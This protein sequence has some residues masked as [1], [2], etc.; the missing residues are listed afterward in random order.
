MTGLSFADPE[1]Y[2]LSASGSH[3]FTPSGGTPHLVVESSE[4]TSTAYFPASAAIDHSADTAWETN[5]VAGT[6]TSL[7]LRNSDSSA[8]TLASYT[9]VARN[10]WQGRAPGEFTLYGSNDNATWTSVDSQT[11]LTDYTLWMSPGNVKN[12]VL[13]TPATFV[14]WK[15]VVTA[16]A[17]DSILNLG[18]IYFN[19]TENPTPVV[20]KYYVRLTD[21]PHGR[22]TDVSF[23]GPMLV[24]NWEYQWMVLAPEYDESQGERTGGQYWNPYAGT[25]ANSSE[26]YG[27]GRDMI[28]VVSLSSL[29]AFSMTWTSRMAVTEQPRMWYDRTVLDPDGGTISFDGTDEVSTGG[30]YRFYSLTPTTSD[31]LTISTNEPNAYYEIYSE[32]GV[33]TYDDYIED[34]WNDAT[35]VPEAGDGTLQISPVPGQEYVIVVYPEQQP[36]PE[37]TWVLTWAQESFVAPY[38]VS[39]DMLVNALNLGKATPGLT[40]AYDNTGATTDVEVPWAKRSIWYRFHVDEPSFVKIAATPSSSDPGKDPDLFLF[41]SDGVTTGTYFDGGSSTIYTYNP[42]PAG[43]EVYLMIAFGTATPTAD[44]EQAGSM[45]FDVKPAPPHT[46][47]V[48][49]LPPG[50]DTPGGGQNYH[51]GPVFPGSSVGSFGVMQIVAPRDGGL[52]VIVEGGNEGGTTYKPSVELYLPYGYQTYVGGSALWR[53]DPYILNTD[54]YDPPGYPIS[55]RT[56]PWRPVGTTTT[57]PVTVRVKAG[58]ILK[59][60]V[61]V[62]TSGA[63]VRWGMATKDTPSPWFSARYGDI[64]TKD[65]TVVPSGMSPEDAAVVQEKVAAWPEVF[66]GPIY[67]GHEIPGDTRA[68]VTNYNTDFVGNNTPEN[69]DALGIRTNLMYPAFQD[70]IESG[71]YGG[72]GTETSYT[73]IVRND[74]AISTLHDPGK[75]WTRQE[76]GTGLRM[77]RHQVYAWG[78]D[79]DQ[80]NAGTFGGAYTDLRPRDPSDRRMHKFI[81]AN[82]PVVQRAGNRELDEWRS[83]DLTTHPYT[84]HYNSFDTYYE[85]LQWAIEWEGEDTDEPN[86][87]YNVYR[88]TDAIGLSRYV[89]APYDPLDSYNGTPIIFPDP[90]NLRLY[91]VPNELTENTWVV[92]EEIVV[93]E[94]IEEHDVPAE[95]LT[96]YDNRATIQPN[97]GTSIFNSHPGALPWDEDLLEA[98]VFGGTYPTT[99]GVAYENTYAMVINPYR[100]RF[101]DIDGILATAWTDH[102]MTPPHYFTHSMGGG[103]QCEMQI[104]TQLN[105]YYPSVFRV[106]KWIPSLAALATEVPPTTTPGAGYYIL[107]NPNLDGVAAGVDVHFASTT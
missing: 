12:F 99:P 1:V 104:S 86:P 59:V 84:G 68:P 97:I 8:I 90:L 41:Y 70:E 51:V 96:G 67:A 101:I 34:G 21:V 92:P 48:Y 103:L 22:V 26:F 81:D 49:T 79:V 76:V 72:R 87:V 6:P 60:V 93:G 78:N 24:Q 13:S 11:G 56:L 3:T 77:V 65:G 63:Y 33:R 36:T 25:L 85:M 74:I 58:D 44:W 46:V 38:I 94:L 53:T 19:D 29:S 83:V 31:P 2:S 37:T 73:N 14:Y 64:A 15:L 47:D 71:A 20:A 7:T 88:W 27:I 43:A 106:A 52:S 45:V 9:L 42:I 28:L 80:W 75:N 10:G 89:R 17:G 54:H 50:V 69:A 5:T 107:P 30:P 62:A 66:Y 100:N 32:S 55:A 39:N 23:S 4:N 16:T 91:K 95:P 82:N 18:E 57:Q 102:S 61:H 98:N 105:R 40:H 35:G